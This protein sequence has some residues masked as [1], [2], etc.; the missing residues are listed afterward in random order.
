MF[1]SFPKFA[2]LSL[3]ATLSLAFDASPPAQAAT[4]NVAAYGASGLTLTT[5]CS[6]SA[7][8]TQFNGCVLP[9]AGGFSVGQGLIV[10]GGGPASQAAAITTPPIVVKG[11]TGATG[12]H[13]YCYVVSAVDPLQGVSAPSPRTCVSNEPDLSYT[14]VFN[15]LGTPNSNVGPSPSFLWYVSED[16][17]PFQLLQV[18]GFSA[19]SMDV[20]QRPGSRG[21]WPSVL[22]ASNPS[23]AKNEDFFTTIT[24]MTLTSMTT[25]DPLPTSFTNALVMHDDTAAIQAAI[26][27]AVAAGGG[28]VQF[29][30][31]TYLVERPSF[32]ADAASLYPAFTTNL[33]FDPWYA[34]FHYLQIPNGSAGNIQLVGVGPATVLLSAPDHGSVSHVLALGEYRRPSQVLNVM[35]MA[36]VAKGATQVVLN[37]ASDAATLAPGNDVYLYSGSYSTNGQPCVD[38]GTNAGGDCHYS[39]LNTVTAV[40]GTT[41]TLQYPTS[42]KYWDDGSSSFGITKMPVTPHNVS[43]QNM[44]IQT[45]N[46]VLG[47][48]MAFNTLIDSVIVAGNSSHGAFGGGFKR[49][50]TIQNSTWGIGVGDA[51]YGATEEYDQFTDVT[52][53][54][55]IINGYA[56]PGSEGVSLMARMYATEGSS[57]FTVTGNHFVNASFLSDQTT[58]D[59]FTNN[60]FQNGVLQVGNAY[61]MVPYYAGPYQ[62]QSFNS[63]ASQ[64]NATI[65][66]NT[67]TTLL[68][69]SPAFVLRLGHYTSA[70]VAGNTFL[71]GGSRDLPILWAYSGSITNNTIVS[72]NGLGS[73]GI[74]AVGDQSSTIGPAPFQISGNSMTGLSAAA[75]VFIPDPGFTDTAAD[76]LQNNIY[77]VPD[78]TAVLIQNPQA[79]NISCQ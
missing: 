48:G 63:F 12:V 4:F 21:G 18:A 52:L 17:G 19:D 35:K 49:G 51:S 34:A 1:V 70:T 56:A 20:G 78:G 5:I 45:D 79:V 54:N 3:A 66:N 61:G 36:P 55:N 27:A 25:A 69:F 53:T 75:G 46:S 24:G 9:A 14:T 44:T 41:L 16:G 60:V 32:I 47:T 57:H 74:A 26:N 71:Y 65:S 58:D 59:V 23:L 68:G 39:E 29:N 50:L 62:D 7:G 33:Q 10:I 28:T 72:S 42:K 13:T 8:T 30:A 6:G 64:D 77:L 11:G 76:C 73:V 43:L 31:G 38:S 40:S 15:A 67:F 37:N 22:P 2:G